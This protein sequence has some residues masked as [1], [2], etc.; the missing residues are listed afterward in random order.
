MNIHSTAIIGEKVKLGKNIIIGAY[1]IIDGN[2]EIGDD[3][4]INSHVAIKGHT[5]IGKRNKI[6][7]FAVIGEDNQDLKYKGEDSLVIIGDNNSIREHCTIHRGTEGGGML[8]QIGNNNL[9]MV[10]THVAHDCIFGNGN[11]IANNATFAGHVT[12]GNNVHIGGLSA[13]HQFVRFGNGSMLGG[14]SGLGEDLIPWGMAYSEVGRRA[15][16]QGLN[17][18][19]LKRAGYEKNVIQNALLF[20]REVFETEEAGS[21]IDKAQKARNSYVNNS[22]VEEI[23][24]FLGTDT[25]RRFCSARYK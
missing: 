3:T 6:F 23:A 12:I 9:L 5:T 4:I 17:L 13:V 14:I 21:L 25:S 10:N 18:V 24:N 2:I 19:G 1:S 15:S 20:Y 16:L 22:I 8:T 11:I 7:P